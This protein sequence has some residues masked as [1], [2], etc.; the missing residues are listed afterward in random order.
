MKYNYKIVQQSNPLLKKK[1]IPEC[2]LFVTQRLTK[3]PLLVEPLI[4]TGVA[5]HEVE[6]LRQALVLVKQILGD[7]DAQVADKERADRKLEIY[8]RCSIK[9]HHF[10]SSRPKVTKLN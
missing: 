1:G 4:K 6:D 2:I 7:V 8:H 3:Y 10:L 5:P 9:L